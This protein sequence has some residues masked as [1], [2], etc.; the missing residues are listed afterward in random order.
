MFWVMR[1]PS[2]DEPSRRSWPCWR[3]ERDFNRTID[4]GARFFQKRV[5][6]LGKGEPFPAERMPFICLVVTRLSRLD[7]T[8]IMAEEIGLKVDTEGYH[9]A[10]KEEQD[11]NAAAV[12]KRK[13]ARSAGADMTFAAEQTSA[14]AHLAKTDDAAKYVWNERPDAK[15]VALFVGR[16]GGPKGDGFVDSVDASCQVAGAVLD[17]TSFYAEMGGQTFDTG[18]LYSS[19][20]L[21]FYK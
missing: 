1:F 9:A 14:I 3:E 6:T 5:S 10:L 13:A 8:E 15:I 16:G 18:S 7:L 12:A 21:P 20:I 4:K 11:R 19:M 17:A 2:Y